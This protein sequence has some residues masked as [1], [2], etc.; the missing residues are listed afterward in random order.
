MDTL[1]AAV[2]STMMQG[3]NQQPVAFSKCASRYAARGGDISRSKDLTRSRNKASAHF[4]SK[5]N[6]EWIRPSLPADDGLNETSLSSDLDIPFANSSVTLGTD[7]LIAEKPTKKIVKKKYRKKKVKSNRKSKDDGG[8]QVSEVNGQDFHVAKTSSIDANPSFYSDIAELCLSP[9]KESRNVNGCKFTP[10]VNRKCSLA[11]SNSECFLGTSGMVCA[12]TSNK[13]TCKMIVDRGCLSLGE[14]VSK[15]SNTDENGTPIYTCRADKMLT[16]VGCETIGNCLD[17]VNDRDEEL[18][19]E[20]SSGRNSHLDRGQIFSCALD[21]DHEKCSISGGGSSGI[22]CD[23]KGVNTGRKGIAEQSEHVSFSY[24]SEGNSCD[25]GLLGGP[26]ESGNGTS[27]RIKSN[28]CCCNI[29]DDPRMKETKVEDGK[30]VSQNLDD[31]AHTVIRTNNSRQNGKENGHSIWQKTPK[32]IR[33]LQTHGTKW[34]NNVYKLA[35]VGTPES[36]MLARPLLPSPVNGPNSFI[37]KSKGVV[38]I[39]KCIYTTYPHVL[40]ESSQWIAQE[41][42]HSCASRYVSQSRQEDMK[43]NKGW[44]KSVEKPYQLPKPENINRSRK[45]F[46]ANKGSLSKPRNKA[47]LSQAEALNVSMDP[48]VCKSADGYHFQCLPSDPPC[49]SCMQ[50]SMSQKMISSCLSDQATLQEVQTHTWIKI[51][52]TDQVLL[53]ALNTCLRKREK[54]PACL[55]V[56]FAYR[57]SVVQDFASRVCIQKWIPVSRKHSLIAKGNGT[58]AHNLKN[59]PISSHAKDDIHQDECRSSVCGPVPSLDCGFEGLRSN[60]KAPDTNRRPIMRGAE[61]EILQ[62][63]KLIG[64]GESDKEHQSTEENVASDSKNTLLYIGSRVAVKALKEA[65]RLQMASECVQ[66]AI[67]CPLAEFERLLHL[68]SPVIIPTSV[69]QHCEECLKNQ[70]ALGD[71]LCN[72]QIPNIPLGMVWKWYE[73]PGNYG[74]EVKAEDSENL[75]GL[76]ADGVS[77]HAHFVPFLSAVQLFGRL[78]DSKYRGTEKPSSQELE[79]REIDQPVSLPGTSA[80]IPFTQAVEN[81]LYSAEKTKFSVFINSVDNSIS[82]DLPGPD[83]GDSYGSSFVLPSFDDMELLFEFFEYEQPQQ[84]RPLYEKI[85]D[86][87][88]TGDSSRK[89]FGDPSRL[90]FMSLHDLHPASW[91]S[92]AWYPIYRIPEGIFRASFLT[93]H[94][95]GHLVQ[96]SISSDS[97]KGDMFSIVSPVLGLQ[98]YN[99]QIQTSS[100]LGCLP[101]AWGLFLMGNLHSMYANADSGQGECWFCPKKPADSSS[102]GFVPFDISEILKER[103]RTLEESASLFARGCVYRGNVIVANHQPDYE[104]FL[105]RKY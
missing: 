33:D 29:G 64:N 37:E 47:N 92:V 49:S 58:G 16:T 50:L 5:D 10:K 102:G 59:K 22:I 25:L 91:Y 39:K 81:S 94:S 93:Y 18:F 82:S 43:G 84:R 55:E 56:E 61:S 97:I 6:S 53:G 32:N 15:L 23:G 44:V 104:F 1:S 70:L 14:S 30:K 62:S 88:K 31:K 38:D 8:I 89:V 41:K 98:S 73:K 46:W 21:S 75:M 54:R 101:D 83:V 63:G 65:Y 72:H 95:L 11:T 68:A 69:A 76:H 77:F 26:E 96:R 36:T 19:S 2:P 35:E 67:G 27:D 100:R 51:P 85:M 105:S 7:S 9:N 12:S 66:M 20:F 87:I 86:L 79:N 42:F 71:P 17:E 28:N 48:C 80:N 99:A 13:E 3:M 90:E 34:S 52:S 57:N 103:L 4:K 24:A 45:G 74:L 78:Q 60:L 40:V